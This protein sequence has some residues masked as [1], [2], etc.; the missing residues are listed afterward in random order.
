MKNIRIIGTLAV[1]VLFSVSSHVFAQKMHQARFHYDTTAVITISGEITSVET[2]TRGW[3]S[4]GGTHLVIKTNDGP[5]T[6]YAGPSNFFKDRI[7]F[8]KGDMIEVTGARTNADGKPGIIAKEIRKGAVKVMLRKDD[9]T[10]LW[11]GQG[12][13]GGR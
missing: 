5:L 11:A 1:V 13:R 10:P 12:R 9:G 2:G 4:A 8:A 3:G 6:V 7:S